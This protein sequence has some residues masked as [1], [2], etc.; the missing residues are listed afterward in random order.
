MWQLNSVWSCNEELNSNVGVVNAFGF[1][2]TEQY[3][4][5]PPKA[6][7]GR[8][9]NFLYHTVTAILNDRTITGRLYGVDIHLN[10][11]LVDAEESRVNKQGKEIRR[12]LG[13]TIVRGDSL[14][15]TSVDAPPP[16]QTERTRPTMST[17]PTLPLP[18]ASAV[19][20]FG[21]AN[22][23]PPPTS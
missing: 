21:P 6:R 20:G 9:E 11:V 17:L 14:V 23:P 13:L 5:M 7:R 15:S 19:P 12:S 16:A 2:L 22:L 1:A 8:L 3:L 4:Q 10:L 18:T